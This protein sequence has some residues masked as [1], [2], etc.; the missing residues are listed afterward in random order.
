MRFGITEIGIFGSYAEGRQ[1]QKSDL[2]ILAN[3]ETSPSLFELVRAE[4]FLSEKTGLKVDLSYKEG[5]KPRFKRQILK[6]AVFI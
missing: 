4:N 1:K 5:L 3:F 2:D 6:H